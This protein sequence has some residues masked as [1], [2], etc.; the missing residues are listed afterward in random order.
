MHGENNENYILRI[1]KKQV[2]QK[3]VISLYVAYSIPH[4]SMLGLAANAIIT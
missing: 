4:A 2:H 3:D 1:S